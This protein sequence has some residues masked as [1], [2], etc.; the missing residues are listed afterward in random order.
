MRLM[1]GSIAAAVALALTG[2]GNAQGAP[3]IPS[4]ERLASAGNAE[5]LYHLGMAYQTGTGTAEDSK[6]ALE[7]FRKA[8]A[9]GDPLAA[10][11][12]GCYY[13]GQGA[14]MIAPDAGQALK[15][16]LIAAQAGY[17]LAQQDVAALYARR[18]DMQTGLAWLEKSAAQG[19][20][21]G[22]MTLASVYNGAPGVGRD[23]A[24]T[25]GYFRLFLA[26]SNPSEGQRNWLSKFETGLSSDDKKRA[27]DLVRDFHPKPTPLTLK[28]LSGHRAAEDLIERLQLGQFGGVFQQF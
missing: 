8:A 5:A 23:A 14:G 19:W 28:A 22:L 12:L 17:A 27:D 9:M 7:A 3:I 16:K 20:S 24:K 11:K 4:L 25:A 6:K 18:G 2:C 13:D 15:Y 10:N 21:G 1:P 26:H